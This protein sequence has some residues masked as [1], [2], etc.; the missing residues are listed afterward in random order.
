MKPGT[1]YVATMSNSSSSPNIESDYVQVVFISSECRPADTMMQEGEKEA[2][3][4]CRLMQDYGRI[5]WVLSPLPKRTVNAGLAQ[6]SEEVER[7]LG[8]L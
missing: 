8:G 3:L 2:N 6:I 5:Y 1:F 4:R 7:R